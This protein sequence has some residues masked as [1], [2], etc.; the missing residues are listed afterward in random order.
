[1]LARLDFET[2]GNIDDDEKSQT[3]TYDY[4]CAGPA[5]RSAILRLQFCIRLS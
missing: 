2:D 3:D 5:N 1:M 4:A